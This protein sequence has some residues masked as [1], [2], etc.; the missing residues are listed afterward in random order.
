M[1]KLWK[2]IVYNAVIVTS[3]SARSNILQE[4]KT[5]LD[6]KVYFKANV[7]NTSNQNWGCTTL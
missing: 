7:I 2:K 3:V 5:K 6:S 1:Q 4:M